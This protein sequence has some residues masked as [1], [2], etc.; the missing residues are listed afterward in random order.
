MAEDKYEALRAAIGFEPS[1]RTVGKIEFSF[2][3]T[4]YKYI[5]IY[6]S[7]SIGKDWEEIANAGL[8]A[9][10]KSVSRKGG[11]F[12]ETRSCTWTG[13]VPV[14]SEREVAKLKSRLSHAIGRLGA[15][16]ESDIAEIESNDFPAE[17]A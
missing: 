15:T 8:A 9:L 5:Y 16:R 14:T 6:I 3:C 4:I 11:G 13:L 1:D 12:S 2:T 7:S 17:S 10:L